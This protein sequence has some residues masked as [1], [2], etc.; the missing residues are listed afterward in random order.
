MTWRTAE[1]RQ[2]LHKNSSFG[3]IR[4]LFSARFRKTKMCA[5]VKAIVL[6]K[7]KTMLL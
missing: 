4:S 3:H 1:I 2:T 6:K 7:N 5:E